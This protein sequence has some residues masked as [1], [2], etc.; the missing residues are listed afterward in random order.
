[1][2]TPL[3]IY[4][5]MY[6]HFLFPLVVL[7]ALQGGRILRNFWRTRGRDMVVAVGVVLVGMG[8][9]LAT[10]TLL[11]DV[12]I[13]WLAV[14][15]GTVA[16]LIVLDQ[17][18]SLRTRLLW[19][20]VGT[21]LALS[22]LVEILVLSGDIGRMNTVFKFYL[23]VW[24]LLALS[25]AVAIERLIRYSFSHP[26]M[27]ARED[28]PMSRL[29]NS[30]VSSTFPSVDDSTSAIFRRLPSWVPS[31]ILNG[32]VLLLL[33]AAL[34]PLLGIP[35]KVR[36]RWNPEAPHT[37]DGARFMAYVTQHEHGHTF[38]LLTD[39]KVIRWFQKHVAHTPTIIEGQ[40]ERE[41]L[42]GNRVSVHTGLPTVA[43]WRWHQVQQR[44]IMPPGTVEKRQFDIR[45][46]YNTPNSERAM[47]ILHQYAVRY[48]VLTPYER[49]YMSPEGEAKFATLVA[50][51]RLQPVYKDEDSTVYLVADTP[52][53]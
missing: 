27:R 20:W 7:A 14:P 37:L 42:W 11:L 22:L 31:L 8:A 5:V 19:F 35:A 18:H 24:M 51:E 26:S 16:A 39:Y 32:F 30:G 36:D 13:A 3:G 28:S 41:Y 25:G 48:V 2:K 44:M 33:A 17:E 53:P 50:Q 34:Y 43:A 49:A 21:A 52:S 15:L 6:G 23:Q 29:I 10:L 1:M 9:L 4:L 12:A 46:F 40:A 38:S 45:D 47:D